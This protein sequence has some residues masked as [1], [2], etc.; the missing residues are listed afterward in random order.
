M[1]SVEQL[2]P[3]G[4]TIM[5]PAPEKM[6]EITGLYRKEK[7]LDKI[8]EFEPF[9][10]HKMAYYLRQKIAYTNNIT[11]NRIKIECGMRW[12]DREARCSGKHYWARWNDRV[13]DFQVQTD[14]SGKYYGNAVSYPAK[15]FYECFDIT[16]FEIKNNKW[17]NKMPSKFKKW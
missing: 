2:N 1:A 11:E 14:K 10:C 3:D 17:S 12:S 7:E 15:K 13:Y 8:I 16:H 4:T 6:I 5:V 9:M